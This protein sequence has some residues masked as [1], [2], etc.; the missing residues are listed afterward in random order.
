MSVGYESHNFDLF[1]LKQEKERLNLKNELTKVHS[2]SE[3][4]FV[5]GIK[6]IFSKLH[7]EI[8]TENNENNYSDTKKKTVVEGNSKNKK[9]ERRTRTT[10]R[11][12]KFTP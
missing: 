10:K 3:K 12:A 1:K 8:T 4:T 9:N 2:N 6:E 5:N 7:K 11:N